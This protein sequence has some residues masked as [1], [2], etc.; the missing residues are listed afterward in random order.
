MECINGSQLCSKQTKDLSTKSHLR[1]NEKTNELKM[2]DFSGCSWSPMRERASNLRRRMRKNFGCSRFFI[3]ILICA[4][5]ACDVIQSYHAMVVTFECYCN[6]KLQMVGNDNF[7][8]L[9]LT[10]ERCFP[11]RNCYNHNNAVCESHTWWWRSWKCTYEK[12]VEICSSEADVCAKFRWKW[13]G[14]NIFLICITVS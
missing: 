7:F 6:M 13:A 8:Q 2:I 1:A 12:N 3:L 11:Q 9:S 4:P 14:D 5:V 10:F